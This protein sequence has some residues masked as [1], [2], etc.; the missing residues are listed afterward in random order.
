MK[1]LF[2]LL[3]LIT[4]AGSAQTVTNLG[5][6]TTTIGER[7]VHIGNNAGSSAVVNDNNDNVYVG[8]QAGMADTNGDHNVFVGSNAGKSNTGGQRNVAVGS[9]AGTNITSGS[10]N[11]VIGLNSGSQLTTTA[12]NTFVGNRAGQVSTS[13]YNS[14]YGSSAGINNTTGSYNCFFGYGAGSTGTIGTANTCLGTN[15]GNAVAASGSNVYVGYET[16]SHNANKDNVM[17]GAFAGQ[18]STGERN[19]FIGHT[20]GMYETGNNKLIIHR[21]TG[22]TSDPALIWGDFS[23]RNLKFNVSKDTLSHVEIRSSTGNR[24]GL[25]FTNLTS[26]Y[27]PP[28]SKKASKFLTVDSNGLV[29]LRNIETTPPGTDSDTSLYLNDGT[30]ENTINNVRVV[31]MA[32]NDLHFQSPDSTAYGRIYIGKHF[33]NSSY[34]IIDGLNEEYKL[35]V[36]KGILTE[37]VKVALRDNANWADYV[38]A[39]DYKLRS[40]GEVETFIKENGHLPGIGSSTEIVKNGLDLGAMQA[41]QMEKIEELTLYAIEQNKILEK[42]SKEIEELKAQVKMLLERK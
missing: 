33:T 2:K 25:K 12:G 29:V 1:N 38:F 26:T 14:F 41:K 15:A 27:N 18:N 35:F 32:D 22:N 5:T 30:L 4:A 7:N 13:N 21:G 39:A 37:K 36:E 23:T 24:S 16:G 8:F 3:F 19:I 9:A 28:V 31:N 34:P 40:L 42:Q 11:V 17:I 6:G 10:E 20:A